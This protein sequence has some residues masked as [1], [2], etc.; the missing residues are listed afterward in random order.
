[1]R[2]AEIYQAFSDAFDTVSIIHRDTYIKAYEGKTKL[3]LEQ[4]YPTIVVLGLSYPKRIIKHTKSLLSPSFYTYGIDYHIVLQSR[5][6]SVMDNL[7]LP[8]YAYVDNH[9]F[10]E[11]LAAILGGNGFF[12]KN[13][14]IIHPDFGSYQFLAIVFIDIVLDFEIR[15]FITDSCGTCHKC[16]DACPTN[17]LTNEG[18]IQEKCISYYNQSK[19]ILTD[20]EIKKN[21]LIFGCDICQLVCPKNIIL[22]DPSHEEF[23]LSGKE[24]IAIKDLFTLPSKEFKNKYNNMA[25]LWRGKTILMRN[26][27]TLLLN[28]NNREYNDLIE[29][30]L[31][32]NLPIWYQETAIKILQQLNYKE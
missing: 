10:D 1:M 15:H 9:A 29:E 28:Q 14:L 7:Q 21:Y 25:Y 3:N 12:G 4:T 23:A 13:Q 11:R 24:Q 20:Q 6:K 8:Y 31:S 22:K 27:L 32:H 30:T 18:Y 2:K 26:A 16:I 19:K 5:I 17:A